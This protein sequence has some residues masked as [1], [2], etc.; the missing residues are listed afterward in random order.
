MFYHQ[1][2]AASQSNCS[3]SSRTN[4]IS[5]K[6]VCGNN[7]FRRSK[8]HGALQFVVGKDSNFCKIDTNH[9]DQDRLVRQTEKER[10]CG[11]QPP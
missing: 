9:S 3:R 8:M 5:S 6:A 1:D 2:S 7:L 10:P 4:R 11:P